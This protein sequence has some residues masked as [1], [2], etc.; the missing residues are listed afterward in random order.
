[1]ASVESNEI[2]GPL[3][4]VPRSMRGLLPLNDFGRART[5]DNLWLGTWGDERRMAEDVHK[6]QWEQSTKE[7]DLALLKTIERQRREIAQLDAKIQRANVAIAM[8]RL[9]S[10]RLH[11]A[12]VVIPG[13]EMAQRSR[14]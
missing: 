5:D 8:S 1:M 11:S 12:F 14:L 3:H 9:N 10:G 13:N 2:F 6:L 7:V 4:Y